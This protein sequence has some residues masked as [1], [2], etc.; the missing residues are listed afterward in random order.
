M[1]TETTQTP[2]IVRVGCIACNVTGI[3]MRCN[4]DGIFAA[5]CNLCGGWAARDIAWA[6]RFPNEEIYKGRL[7]R[8]I[9]THVVVEGL[10]NGNP[11]TWTLTY[12]QFLDQVPAA[13][14][15]D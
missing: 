13:E 4:S 10:L 9:V 3:Q 6:S 12:D 11:V 14:V 2:I 7:R 1:D 15:I 8:I 5:P